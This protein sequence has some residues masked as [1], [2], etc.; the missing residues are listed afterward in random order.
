[1]RVSEVYKKAVACFWTVEEIDFSKDIVDWNKLKDEEKYFISHV[2]AFFA[3]SDGIVIENLVL[4]FMKEFDHP[5]VRAFIHFR[6][7]LNRSILKPI[8][9][10]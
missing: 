4:R 1:M 3:G 10:L 8:R 6:V 5:E 7:L 9:C 2:L